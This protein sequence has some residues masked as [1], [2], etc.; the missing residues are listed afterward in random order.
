VFKSAINTVS[1]VVCI[2]LLVVATGCSNPTKRIYEESTYGKPLEVPPDLTL[3]SFD[4]GLELSPGSGRAAAMPVA[5]TSAET[6]PLVAL[7][8]QDNMVLMRD[9]AQRWLVL[10]GEPAQVWSW[11]R[12]FWLKRGF[13][14]SVEDPT[15]GVMETEWTQQPSSLPV[16]STAPTKADAK[17]Y[18]VPTREKFRVRFDRGDK[19]GTTEL[20][21]SHRGVELSEQDKMIAWRLRATDRELE[22]E[23]LKQL[24]VYLG[25]AQ[26]KAGGILAAPKEI[27]KRATVVADAQ[28]IAVVHIDEDFPRVWRRVELAL[29][30]LDY[31]IE[32]RDRSTGVF[33]VIAQDSIAELGD[34]KK[35]S[36]F[37]RLFS[38]D[39]ESQRQYRIVLKDEGEATNVY[40]RDKSGDKLENALA[41]PVLKQLQTKLQ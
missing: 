39:S 30:R 31:N 22:N 18:V 17:T 25:V 8:N 40:V 20:Y 12:S 35:K 16:S 9:G 38:S 27:I 37:G 4:E 36:W 21:V 29:D 1:G 33:F 5:V 6:A 41:E 7:P 2:T 23:L 26:E 14:L 28:G 32:D 15:T 10:N 34:G 13:A 3:P 24:M 11:V 19:P